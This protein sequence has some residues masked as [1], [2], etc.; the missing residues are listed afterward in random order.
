MKNKLTID[1]IKGVIA[2]EEYVFKGTLTLC[3]LT[4]KNGFFVTGESACL[5][6]SNYDQNTGKKIAFERALN[7]IWELEGYLVKQRLFES[8]TDWRR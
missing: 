4:L 5:D 8:T 7:K 1:E 3:I 2:Q 6:I